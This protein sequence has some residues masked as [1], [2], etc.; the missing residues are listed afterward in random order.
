MRGLAMWLQG[1][2]RVANL[3]VVVW[4]DDARVSGIDAIVPFVRT[5]RQDIAAVR[6]AIT[7]TCSNGL[8]RKPE[9]V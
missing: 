9:I 3:E 5:R 6:N 7:E 8:A 4:L 1:I 2:L